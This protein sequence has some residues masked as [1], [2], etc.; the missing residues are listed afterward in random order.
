MTGTAL[1][2]E[3]CELSKIANKITATNIQNLN[4]VEMMSP[5]ENIAWCLLKTA[6]LPGKRKFEWNCIFWL[7][8]NLA[9]SFIIPS[10]IIAQYIHHVI[11]FAVKGSTKT[12]ASIHQFMG[13]H[14]LTLFNLDKDIDKYIRVLKL[15]V[16]THP[17]PN[18]NGGLLKS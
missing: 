14:S 15:Y 10:Y 7:P 4:R 3:K 16:I 12:V 9:T 2:D 1:I 6:Y 18:F 11:K 5:Y 13:P 8:P 17:R